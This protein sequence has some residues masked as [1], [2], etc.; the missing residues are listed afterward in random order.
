[1]CLPELQVF[2]IG[3]IADFLGFLMLDSVVS[4]RINY[5]FLIVCFYC[6]EL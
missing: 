3:I 5:Y 2:F 6:L 1:M 4:F